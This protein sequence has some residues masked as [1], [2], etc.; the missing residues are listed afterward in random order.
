VTFYV[1][2]LFPQS[3]S[4]VISHSILK[5]AQDKK[6][7]DIK[8][9]NIRDFAKDKHKTVDGKPYGGG[10]GMVLK[11]DVVIN[12]LQSIKTKPYTILLSANG[13]KYNN[14]KA[15]NLSKK[16]NIALICGHYEGIDQRVENYTN[17]IISIGD[18]VLTGGEIPAMVLIDSITRFIPHVLNP[19]SPM[20]DSFE[21]GL[22]E[23]PQYTRPKKFDG[24]KVPKILLNGN[25][26]QINNWRQKQPLKRTQKFRPD[27]ILKN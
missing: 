22:L 19:N 27:L 24:Y 25:H 16:K 10:V 2:T 23:Y 6:I 5:K 3:F 17:E 11:V 7:I 9:V 21:K 8:I 4:Q 26:N 14:Q 1:L 20:N 12:A 15:K 13:K 18:Y